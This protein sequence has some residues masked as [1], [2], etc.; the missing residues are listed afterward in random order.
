MQIVLKGKTSKIER[1]G[2]IEI[3]G[4]GKLQLCMLKMEA[5]SIIGCVNFLSK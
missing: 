3:P 5:N 2:C 4:V 1:G